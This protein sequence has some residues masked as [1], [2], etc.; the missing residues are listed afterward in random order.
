MDALPGKMPE[1]RAELEAGQEI[2]RAYQRIRQACLLAG[3]SRTDSD[4]VAQDLL[5]WLLRG[6]RA[7]GDTDLPWLGASAQNF[8][9]RYWR[10]RWLRVR[11]EAEAA[12]ELSGGRDEWNGEEE[13][14]T[15]LFLDRMQGTLPPVEAGLLHL[16]REGLSFAEAAKALKIP[17]GSHNFFRRRLFSHLSDGL[18]RGTNRNGSSPHPLLHPTPS[19][20]RLKR[21]YSTRQRRPESPHT[22]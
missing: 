17:H 7:P 9:R 21:P 12:R 13:M 20:C 19:S 8:I 5:L 11:R 18:A 2:E 6:G 3:L 22:R 1:S 16:V 15:R 4:D 14:E 10:S